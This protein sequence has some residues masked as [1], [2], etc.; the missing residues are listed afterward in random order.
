MIEIE[1]K[2]RVDNNR[3]ADIVERIGRLCPNGNSIRQMDKVYL[4][5]SD[6]FKDFKSG[7]PVVRIRVVDDKS[8]LT[9]KRAIDGHGNTIEHEIAFTPIAEG[10]N[11]LCEMGYKMVTEVAKTRS[12]WKSGDVT[13]SLDD[14]DGLGAF[15]ELEILGDSEQIKPARERILTLAHELGLSESDIELKKYDQLVSAKQ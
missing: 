3:R 6:S 7:D 12:V 10:E 11:I 8:T 1:I 9:Y 13:I 5:K 14:V 4:I 2:F 15:L